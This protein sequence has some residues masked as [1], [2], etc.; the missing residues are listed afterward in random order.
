MDI[1]TAAAA[2]SASATRQSLAVAMARQ[3]Q[4]ADQ[5]VVALLESGAASARAMLPQGVGQRLDVSA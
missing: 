4:Q 1:A 5:A 3:N 2:M